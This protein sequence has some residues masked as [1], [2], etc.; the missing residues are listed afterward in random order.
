[1]PTTYSECPEPVLAVA[2][3][4]IVDGHPAIIEADVTIH[5]LFARREDGPAIVHGGYPAKALVRKNSLRDRVAGLKDVTILIDESGWQDWSDDHRRAVLDH[6]LYHVEVRRDE[7]GAIQYD[8]AN[9]PKIKLRPHD[10]QFG[11]FHEMARRHKA[12]SAEVQAVQEVSRVWAQGIFEFD[13]AELA[14]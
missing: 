1:M 11:G 14:T 3:K 6:E 12:E 8:D 2:R 10:F 13:L 5:Y 4:L 7:S 9:R